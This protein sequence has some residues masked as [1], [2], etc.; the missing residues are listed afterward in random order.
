[1]KSRSLL[2][3]V[4]AAA[5]GLVAM[6][7]VM[8]VLNNRP[9]GPETVDL[10]VAAV[11]IAPGMPLTA[12]NVTFQPTP[13]NIAPA[14]ALTSLEQIS[15]KAMLGKTMAGEII[16][17]AKLGGPEAITASHQIPKGLRVHTI[18][19]DATKSHSGLIR[20]TDRVDVLCAYKVQTPNSRPETHVK[21]V[22]EYI[23]VFAVDATRAGREGEGANDKG[24]KTV[25]NV[26]VLVTPEQ[27][28]LLTAAEE[29]GELGLSLRNRGDQEKT[30]V[31]ELTDSSF[32]GVGTSQG[33]RVSADEAMTS[34]S[35]TM[36][37]APAAPTPAAA[38]APAAAPEMPVWTMAI[39]RGETLGGVR[40][41][42][43]KAL[44]ADMSTTD[45]HRLRQQFQ[46]QQEAGAN[47]SAANNGTGSSP[48][49]PV[50]TPQT[51]L[52]PVT[53]DGP[54]VSAPNPSLPTGLL[55][56]PIFPATGG[57]R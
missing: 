57:S 36:T 11:D 20:P 39:G 54:Q 37:S 12:D 43:D 23:E 38:L 28:Q 33:G 40:V 35:P 51:P 9:Q 16:L 19:V 46:A 34:T 53:S 29:L 14:G 1:M 24:D 10:L 13:L 55:S 5:C 45:R 25:K 2:L 30:D 44:P 21:T 50:N 52:P 32:F 26:S 22:L 7:G 31:A 48:P 49:Q 15:G 18:S 3:L 4:V 41:I 56:A 6:L 47:G 27:L 17:E 8:Q 42:D